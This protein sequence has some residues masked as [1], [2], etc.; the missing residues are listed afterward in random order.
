MKKNP[1]F[2]HTLGVEP[3]I[4]WDSFPSNY[5]P[6]RSVSIIFDFLHN[7]DVPSLNVKFAVYH[8]HIS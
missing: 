7:L 1:S 4:A 8:S 5:P 3:N 2:N 6:N